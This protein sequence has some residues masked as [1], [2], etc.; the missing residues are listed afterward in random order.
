L[1]AGLQIRPT[2]PGLV[3]VEMI[4]ANS[5]LRRPLSALGGQ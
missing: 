1:R 2:D 3:R 4:K 5:G